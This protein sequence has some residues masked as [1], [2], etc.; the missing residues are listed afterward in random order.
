MVKWGRDY[1][2]TCWLPFTKLRLTYSTANQLITVGQ[3]HTFQCCA[4][5]LCRLTF[6]LHMPSTHAHN[7]S[8]CDVLSCAV[9]CRAVT[10]LC[11]F[12]FLSGARVCQLPAVQPAAAAARV[13]QCQQRT[14][15]PARPKAAGHLDCGGTVSLPPKGRWPQQ[16]QQ[17]PPSR[18]DGSR[19]HTHWRQQHQQRQWQLQ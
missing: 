11:R 13:L 7:L 16:P 14:L 3:L 18:S 10:V 15:R 9:P 6:S 1:C 17:L 12:S 5:V 4:T 8:Q 2:C 19:Q